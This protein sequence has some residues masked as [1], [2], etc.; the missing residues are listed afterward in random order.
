M[1]PH[2]K[3]CKKSKSYS[4]SCRCSLEEYIQLAGFP[5]IHFT[6][7]RSLLPTFQEGRMPSV[8]IPY[9]SP[10]QKSPQTQAGA[11]FTNPLDS[12]Y[13]SQFDDQAESG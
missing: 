9:V 8:A 1:Y 13:F 10:L 6:P 7:F 11:I 5:S 4:S 2:G 3:G 12:S